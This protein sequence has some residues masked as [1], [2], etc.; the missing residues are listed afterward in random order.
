MLTSD[1]W[2]LFTGHD[3]VR[4]ALR[5]PYAIGETKQGQELLSALIVDR[6]CRIGTIGFMEAVKIM[7][8]RK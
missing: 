7:E 5:P 3:G 8:V 6:M 1:M 2:H 4:P